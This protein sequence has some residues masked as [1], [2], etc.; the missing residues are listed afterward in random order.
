MEQILIPFEC[1]KPVDHHSFILTLNNSLISYQIE[2]NNIIIN[3][4]INA[5]VILLTIK[6]INTKENFVLKIKDFILNKVSSRQTLYLAFSQ[7]EGKNFC[8]T[9]LT[10]RDNII[11]I[12]FGNPMSWWLSECA[13]K[14][15][16]MSYGT[17]LYDQ[18]NIFY[19]KSIEIDSGFPRIMQDFMKH[20]LGFHIVAKTEYENPLHNKKI[21]YLR[22]DLD[23]DEDALFD[24]F[25]RN[26]DLLESDDYTPKQNEYNK[27]EVEKL[28]LWQISMAV[29]TNKTKNNIGWK[30]TI[31]YKKEQFPLFYRL[32]EQITDI[33]GVRIVQ[34]FIGQ[35]K[36]HSYVAPHVDDLYKH[37]D[38]F[39]N[40]GGC[41]QLFI[42]IK[43][44]KGNY[45]KFADIGLI[46]YDQGALLSSNGEFMHGSVNASDNIRFTIG[47]LCEF[48]DDSIVNLLSHC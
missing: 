47:I 45:Y 14:I 42:P 46:P 35:V 29:R 5:G 27:G 34:A 3:T 4:E 11:T 38:E 22:V 28:D 6:L 1:D 23:Y 25:S 18:Y 44:K 20:N 10:D 19:P 2:N 40:T 21:P 39:I 9:W 26:I 8:T 32:L 41:S 24:E 16:N 33:G 48:T 13:K 7:L 12:P 30:D 36:P 37:R 15:P 17:N 31:I 43:W